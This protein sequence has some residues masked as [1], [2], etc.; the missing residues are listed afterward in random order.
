MW[1]E[2]EQRRQQRGRV[3]PVRRVVLTQHAVAHTVLED[4][5][6]DLVSRGAPLALLVA[7]AAD[8]SDLSRSVE[9]DPA[10]QLRGHVLL[11]RAARLPDAL[12]GVAPYVGSA[13]RLR[14]DDR[15]EAPRQ[16]LAAQ[17]VQED[18]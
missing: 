17:G 1:Q 4:V 10:H 18:R 3:E 9:R 14:L 6:L 13:L 8:R 12:V 16:A 5:G 2:A 7:V 11:R 15:P